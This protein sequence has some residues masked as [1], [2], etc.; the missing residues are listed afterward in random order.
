MCM[1]IPQSP[2]PG[3]IL[4]NTQ[5]VQGFPLKTI[6]SSNWWQCCVARDLLDEPTVRNKI[7]VE[8]HINLASVSQHAGLGLASN[9]RMVHFAMSFKP[10][11]RV[12]GILRQVIS[13]GR[14]PANVVVLLE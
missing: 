1:C 12:T 8:F 6:Q 13:H 2:Q 14:I 7:I 9:Q 10:K 3:V 4:A 11:R 5:V